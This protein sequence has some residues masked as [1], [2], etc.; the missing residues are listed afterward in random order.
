MFGFSGD[1][2]ADILPRL[3]MGLPWTLC[4]FLDGGTPGLFPIEAWVP[5]LSIPTTKAPPGKVLWHLGA[6]L[7]EGLFFCSKPLYAV[8]CLS[9]FFQGQWIKHPRSIT[10][11]LCLHQVPLGMNPLLQELT[12]AHGLPF[13]YSSPPE[14]FVS[15]I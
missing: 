6:V 1:V 8:C 4:H 15:F 14:L 13:A 2:V 5:C 7:G 11:L 12:P 9:Y 10:K 3:S